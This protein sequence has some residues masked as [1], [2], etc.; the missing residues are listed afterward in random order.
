[1]N[2][3]NQPFHQLRRTVAE[4]SQAVRVSDALTRAARERRERGDLHADPLLG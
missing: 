2:Y 3:K 1:M 4:I